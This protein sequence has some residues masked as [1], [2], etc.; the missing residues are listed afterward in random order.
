MLSREDGLSELLRYFP[1][2]PAKSPVRT[3]TAVTPTLVP[4]G[5]EPRLAPYFTEVVESLPEANE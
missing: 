4:L 5:P 3:A 2:E 1:L